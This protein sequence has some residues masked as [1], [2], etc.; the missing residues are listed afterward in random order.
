MS[1]TQRERKFIS[2]ADK[3][4]SFLLIFGVL[5]II[6]PILFVFY[7]RMEPFENSEKIFPQ[8]AEMRTVFEHDKTMFEQHKNEIVSQREFDLYNANLELRAGI[9]MQAHFVLS[10]MIALLV[11]FSQVIGLLFILW[12]FDRR[13][14]LRIIKNNINLEED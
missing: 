14:V 13:R 6:V 1:L 3:S 5:L 8:L 10:T 2:Q 12:A 7:I 9:L 11:R 4:F